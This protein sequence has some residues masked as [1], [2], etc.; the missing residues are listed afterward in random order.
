MSQILHGTLYLPDNKYR[1]VN[2][3]VLKVVATKAQLRTNFAG[4]NMAERF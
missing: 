4:N 1:E 2:T 3:N